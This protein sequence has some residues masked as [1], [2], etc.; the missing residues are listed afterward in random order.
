MES[1]DVP[2]QIRR[3][4]NEVILGC[5]RRRGGE[6]EY[7]K[8]I[9]FRPAD[10]MDRRRFESW[11]VKLGRWWPEDSRNINFP[12]RVVGSLQRLHFQFPAFARRSG[13]DYKSERASEREEGRERGGR[14]GNKEDL[15]NWLGNGARDK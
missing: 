2:N 14:G 3:P 4:N 9:H 10:A 7:L 8:R 6:E 13:H 11:Q 1:T 12:A 15:L 5:S